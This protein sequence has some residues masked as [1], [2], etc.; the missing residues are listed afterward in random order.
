M[1][2]V[3]TDS[4]PSMNNH[5]ESAVHQKNT[6][7]LESSFTKESFVNIEGDASIS[8]RGEVYKSLTPRRRSAQRTGTATTSGQQTPTTCTVGNLDDLE[9]IDLS[10]LMRFDETPATLLQDVKV[11]TP[12]TPKTSVVNSPVISRRASPAS[13]STSESEK[14]ELLRVIAGSID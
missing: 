11:P 2:N 14:L 10:D 12:R 4:L 5:L 8:R 3:C 1:C 6:S 9:T 7:R 13:P